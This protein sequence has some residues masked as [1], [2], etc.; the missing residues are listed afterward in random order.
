MLQAVIRGMA[1][2]SDVSEN[3]LTSTVF[4]RLGYMPV[5]PMWTGL[6]GKATNESGAFLEHVRAQAC[7]AGVP[8]DQYGEVRL[9][10]W[11]Q[12]P[13]FGEPDLVGCFVGRGGPPLAFAL[14]VKLWG[15]KDRDGDDQLKRY[16]KA[17]RDQTF[18]DRVLAVEG[19]RPLGLLYVTPCDEREAL[20]ATRRSGDADRHAPP[21]AT[22]HLAWQDV[23]EV[24]ASC[25]GLPA[26]LGAMAGDVAEFLKA[27]RLDRFQGFRKLETLRAFEP[28]SFYSGGR[29]SDRRLVARAHPETIREET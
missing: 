9:S 28:R 26:P 12:H 11:P 22:Y 15:E 5:E 2:R 8:L 6:F 13:K 7:L 19:S 4:G 16:L 14:E 27:V 23:H 1:N 10:F 18:V 3:L 21:F 20:A 24:A 17:V 25:T 29:R